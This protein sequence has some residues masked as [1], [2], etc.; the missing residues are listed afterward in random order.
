MKTTFRIFIALVIAGPMCFSTLRAQNIDF[1]NQWALGSSGRDA[2]SYCAID[3]Q[4]NRIIF[5]TFSGNVDFNPNGSPFVLTPKGNPDLFIASYDEANELNFAFSLGRIAM[6]DGVFPRGLVIEP[7]GDIVIAGSFRQTIDFNPGVEQLL[8]S[9]AGGF[10]AFLVKYDAEGQLVW[11]R[12]IGSF[13]YDAATALTGG[14]NGQLFLALHF[15]DSIDTDLGPEEDW[16]T[17]MGDRD[18]ALLTWSGEGDLIRTAHIKPGPENE[19]ITALKFA[20]DHGLALGMQVAGVTVGGFPQSSLYLAMIDTMGAIQW[21]F[22]FDN[23]EQA[24]NISSLEFSQDG[25]AL[26]VAGR[27][28][29]ITDFDPGDGEAILT[30][31]FSDIFLGRYE[32]SSGGLDWINHVESDGTLDFATGIKE[33]EDQILLVGAFDL[34]A[35]FIPGDFTSQVVS[36]GGRDMFV[37]TYASTTG[38]FIESQVFGD[39]GDEHPL[40]VVFD[41]EGTIMVVGSFNES[42]NLANQGSPLASQGFEDGF[43]AIFHRDTEVATSTIKGLDDIL[44]FPIPAED[45]LHILFDMPHAQNGRL[46]VINM[47]GSAVIENTISRGDEQIEIAVQD[48]AP[49]VYFVEIATGERRG[50]VKFMKR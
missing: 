50:T 28:R 36:S 24:N 48:L 37:A 1:V 5:G 40:D 8:L 31:L 43:V 44:V 30:P 18:A 29:G 49:G 11:G 17:A 3:E 35:R 19:F 20:P 14:S 46:R 45:V 15:A 13:G 12:S 47:L 21:E 10:D 26:Y 42:L 33:V 9:S 2:A 7:N 39:V 22:D 6:I 34:N 32:V 25:Q 38:A 27:F 41:G 16:L 4:G 23:L